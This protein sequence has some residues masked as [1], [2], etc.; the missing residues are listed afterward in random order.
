MN[1]GYKAI[2]LGMFDKG[3][4]TTVFVT[5]LGLVCAMTPIGR[6]PA[7]EELSSILLYAVVSLLATQAPL[8]D[9]ISAPMWV[10]YG[11]FVLIIHVVVRRHIAGFTEEEFDERV[12]AGKI[13]WIY[14]NGEMRF[15]TDF[16]RPCA[17]PSRRSR[18]ARAF[19]CMA[20]KA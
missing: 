3:T 10:V 13:G 17:R 1:T 2:G 11:V 12:D 19:R 16:S 15:L 9:L 6:L 7:V 14:L 4:C 18:H 20:L 8:N 5:V